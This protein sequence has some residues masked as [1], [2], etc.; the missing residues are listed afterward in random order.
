MCRIQ[1]YFKGGVELTFDLSRIT[2]CLSTFNFYAVVFRLCVAFI[3]G[4]LIGID[5]GIKRKGAGIKTHTLVCMSAALVMLTSEYIGLNFSERVD[6]SRLGAQVISG[7]GFLGVGTIIVTGR[8]QIRGLT[9]AAS[10]WSCACIGLAVGIGFISGALIICGF[11]LVVL[12]L[13]PYIDTLVHQKSDKSEFYIEF[14]NTDS[15]NLF[16]KTIREMGMSVE[17]CDTIKPQHSSSGVATFMTLSIDDQ[18]MKKT[19]IETL[20]SITGVRYI[21]RV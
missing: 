16:L 4:G 18:M 19:S 3:I 10:I 12:H 7:V 5:R 14:E 1:T 8:Q 21:D 20:G 13:L 15:I 9:T 2:S 11:I 6:M 17:V